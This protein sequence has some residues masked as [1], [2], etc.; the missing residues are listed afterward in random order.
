M[1]GVV[2]PG[3]GRW[4]T[5]NSPSDPTGSVYYKVA[6]FVRSNSETKVHR[7]EEGVRQSLEQKVGL[8]SAAPAIQEQM[9][10]DQRSSE[11]VPS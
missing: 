7:L 8:S 1:R 5:D 9:D 3:P 6:L 10:E 11:P 2:G 4:E